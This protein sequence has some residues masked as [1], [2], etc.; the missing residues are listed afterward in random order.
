MPGGTAVAGTLITT[1]CISVRERCIQIEAHC[2][3]NPHS[4]RT[5][6]NVN[7]NRRIMHPLSRE[8]WMWRQS[9]RSS[10]MTIMMSNPRNPSSY[11]T[12]LLIGNLPVFNR[13][14][15][16]AAA[17]AALTGALDDSLLAHIASLI[18]E[19]H[20]YGYLQCIPVN[21]FNQNDRV[22]YLKSG[23]GLNLQPAATTISHYPVGGIL[24]N[25]PILARPQQLIH[26]LR[27]EL[28]L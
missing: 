6:P 9:E 2:P 26:L 27:I 14:Q 25:S 23:T 18:Y 16:A 15:D 22:V 3:G 4:P 8:T 13:Y 7:L 12:L 19:V 20:R 11:G 17:V 1:E 10:F 28:S 21:F 5:I 24:S